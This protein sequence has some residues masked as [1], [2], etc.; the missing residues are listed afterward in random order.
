MHDSESFSSWNLGLKAN[1]PDGELTIIPS[2]VG[3]SGARGAAT[4]PAI[5]SSLYINSKYKSPEKVLEF[6]DYLCQEDVK[7]NL[8]FGGVLAEE[9][10]VPTSELDVAERDYRRLITI[11]YDNSYNKYMLPFEPNADVMQNY[12]DNIAGEEGYHSYKADKLESFDKH[13]DLIPGANCN[14]WQEY[15]AKI[16]YGELPVSAYDEF[17]AEYLKRGGQD[18]VDEATSLYKEGKMV[19]Y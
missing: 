2:P 18:I 11:V 6:L 13:P 1:V 7:K 14:L 17:V 8:I 5:V 16:F 4:T 10:V 9:Y 19:K 12:I 15:A 3:S